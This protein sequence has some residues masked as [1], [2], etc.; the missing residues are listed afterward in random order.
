MPTNDLVRVRHIHAY[1]DVN[2]DI[3]WQT[4]NQDLPPLIAQLER[5]L[6]S[7]PSAL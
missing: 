7:P 6:P 4:I 2:L 3:D 5:V 1:F